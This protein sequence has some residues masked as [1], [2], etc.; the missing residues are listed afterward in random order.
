MNLSVLVLVLLGLIFLL[1]VV[2][3]IYLVRL[4]LRLDR[5]KHSVLKEI[6]H[7]YHRL[8]QMQKE[9]NEIKQSGTDEPSIDYDRIEE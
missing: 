9:I 2:L 6:D 7:I 5:I 3:A 8:E 1:M 4:I